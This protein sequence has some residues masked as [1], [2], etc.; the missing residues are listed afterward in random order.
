MQLLD[1]SSASSMNEAEH[2]LAVPGKSIH[3]AGLR[4]YRIASVSTARSPM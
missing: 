4:A 3:P 1:G 2:V